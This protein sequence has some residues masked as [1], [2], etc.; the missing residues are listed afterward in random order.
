MAKIAL[1]RIDY[2]GGTLQKH[3]YQQ[4][5]PAPC[6]PL[7]SP[8]NSNSPDSGGWWMDHASVEAAIPPRRKKRRV[9]DIKI[10]KSVLQKECCSR[11]S[12]GRLQNTNLN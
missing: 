6:N 3:Y 2:S 11:T 12:F 5:H 4:I 10:K 1:L 8:P 9:K 7:L